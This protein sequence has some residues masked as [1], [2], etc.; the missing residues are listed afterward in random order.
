M[1]LAAASRYEAPFKE[2]DR[3][4]PNGAQ[5]LLQSAI[6]HTNYLARV[7]AV[8]AYLALLASVVTIG[9]KASEA[10]FE[11][12]QVIELAPV[13]VEDPPL[14][15]DTPPPEPIAL[16][17]PPP[18]QALDP[19]APVE[20]TKPVAPPKPKPVQKRMEHVPTP[21]HET[22]PAPPAHAQAAPRA[23]APAVRVP[24]AAPGAA[25]SAIANHFHS[26][27]QRAAA[28]AYPKSQAPRTAHI[29]YR[30]AFSAS[31]SL[32]SYSITPSGN[33][34]FDAVANR[35]GGRCGSVPSPG[36]PVSLSGSL[37][38]SP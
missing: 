11:E 38:F 5:S 3:H 16:P 4:D 29:S 2:V 31:G 33:S 35:L 17:E 25:P 9:F 27:M 12:Q 18:P 7:G 24:A 36:T 23:E 19:I 15:E 28:N 21:R 10:P 6:P 37:T 34:A 13:P 26:C 20:E 22:R 30:A 32:T 14:V 1:S 8:F